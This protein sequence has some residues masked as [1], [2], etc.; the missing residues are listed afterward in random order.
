MRHHSF[1]WDADSFVLGHLIV[2]WCA[3]AFGWPNTLIETPW[4]DTEGTSG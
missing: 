4:P 2:W 3:Q 1:I